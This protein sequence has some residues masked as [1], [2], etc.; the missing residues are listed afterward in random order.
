ME[1]LRADLLVVGFGKGGKTLAGVLGRRGRRVILI[2]QSAAMYGG[3]CINVACVPTKALLHDADARPDEADPRAWYGQAVTRKDGITAAMRAK[4]FEML[5]QVDTVTVLTGRAEL[6]GAHELHVR[7]GTDE[8]RITAETIVLNTGSVPVMPPIPGASGSPRVY[9]STTLIAKRDLPGRLAIVGGG[10]IGLELANLYREFG[11]EVTVLESGPAILRREDDD[12]ADAVRAVLEEAGVR[13]VTHATATS[14]ADHDGG[15]TVEFDV[16]G[17]RGSVDVD[18]VLIAVGRQPD[19][20]G[21]GLEAAGVEVDERGAIVVDE[22]LRT[23]AAGI[24]AVGDVN[25][26]PQFTYIS[27]DDHR[28]VL[29]Q[30]TGSGRRSTRD[31]VA[32]PTTVFLSPPLSTVGM[33]EREARAAGIGLLVAR[34]PVAQIATMPRSRIV[35]DTRGLMKVVID[36]ES[37]RILGASL[38]CID[39]QEVINL[40]ALAMRHDVPAGALRD[41][42]WI[43]PSTSEGLNELLGAAQPVT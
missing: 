24:Y 40:V 41:G 12:V 20:D 25:G 43:H 2:E 28:I 4:N 27:L 37:D 30:L 18:A 38:F 1:S 23:T 26:G 36:A 29:D 8:L 11:S 17:T 13:I 22:H 39:S 3:T 9:T 15:A 5:D 35:G 34:K 31:R 32:V 19:T 14:V 16:R 33:T 6:T 21:L 10:Y 42:I 7:A